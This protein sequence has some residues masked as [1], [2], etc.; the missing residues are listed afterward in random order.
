MSYEAAP[1]EAPER[2]AAVLIPLYA[3]HTGEVRVVITKRPDTMPTHAGH[4]AFPGGRHHPGDD[5]FTGT[6]LR[7]AHEEVGIDPG[8]VEI[9]GFLPSV[10]TVE[11]RRMVV[12]V[13][14]RVVPEPVLRPSPREVT[15]V[16]T[17]TLRSLEDVD[18]W[19][20]ESWNG[21]RVWFHEIEG[22]TLWGAT[23]AMTRRLLGLVL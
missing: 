1:P 10:D 9:L 3:D 21:R 19:R 22:E 2:S 18:S 13:V 4:L 16:L 12:P 5:G 8:D 11:F 6:A 20:S 23:A 15:R 14:G 7:E 17:P